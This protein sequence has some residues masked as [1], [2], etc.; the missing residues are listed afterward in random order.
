MDPDRFKNF[1]QLAMHRRRA[2]LLSKRWL[3]ISV[4]RDLDEAIVSSKSILNLILF[5][6][7]SN[8]CYHFM[9]NSSK[10]EE[11][12]TKKKMIK[13]WP[14]QQDSINQMVNEIENLQHELDEQ[15]VSLMKGREI[16][17]SWP[18]SLKMVLLMV[19][20]I[21]AKMLVLN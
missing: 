12:R 13:E 21:F 2:K 5:Y 7:A 6:V 10:R 1:V 17:K 11:W 16:R 20:G 9:L 14:E 15:I 18:N 8:G 4:N 3:T 19:K